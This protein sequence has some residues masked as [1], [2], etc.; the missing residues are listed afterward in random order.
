MVDKSKYEQLL[1]ER[2][3]VFEELKSIKYSKECLDQKFQLL[4]ENEISSSSTIQSLST[5][6]AAL[7]AKLTAAKEEKD[8]A[9]VELK[10]LQN[11]LRQKDALIEQI[12]LEKSDQIAKIGEVG[13]QVE[14]LRFERQ[15]LIADN[16]VLN[17]EIK[18]MKKSILDLNSFI[19]EQKYK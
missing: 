13:K 12:E 14:K 15:N 16:N 10:S 19:E 1:E 3:Q 11:I 2:H 18:K 4:N 17:E 5:R 8:L 9:N 7:Q 6:I